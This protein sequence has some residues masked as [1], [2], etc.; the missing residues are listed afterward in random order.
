M[1]R[2]V[3]AYRVF[4]RRAR[5]LSRRNPRKVGHM[6]RKDHGTVTATRHGKQYTGSWVV[7]GRLI[8]VSHPN[9]GAKSTQ[10]GGSVGAP[11]SLARV[12][13]GELISENERK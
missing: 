4:R 2:Y 10:L 8:T 6:A 7:T 11:E 12:M 3:P 9:L 1:S 13:L 5:E